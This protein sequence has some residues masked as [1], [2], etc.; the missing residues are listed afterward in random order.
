MSM[1]APIIRRSAGEICFQVDDVEP[2]DIDLACHLAADQLAITMP[3]PVVYCSL[4]PIAELIQTGHYHPLVSAVHLAFSQHRP[5]VLT[6]DVIW[7]TIAQGFAHHVRNNAESLRH[8]LVRHEGKREVSVTS[9]ELSRPEHWAAAIEGWVAALSHYS[10]PELAALLL[11][12]FS[13]TTRTA[14][15]ASQVVLMD[16]LQ[17]YFKYELISVC[18]IPSITLTGTPADWQSIRDRV[19]RLGD[20]GLGWWTDRLLVIC[21]GLIQTAVGQPP[22]LFWQHIYKPRKIYGGEVVTGWLADL[23][24]YMRH[25]LCDTAVVRNPIL[26]KRRPDVFSPDYDEHIKISRDLMDLLF[27]DDDDSPSTA[28]PSEDDGVLVVGDGL[29]PEDFPSGMSEVPFTLRFG[30]GSTSGKRSLRL[31]AGLLG[32]RRDDSGALQPEIGWAIC[33]R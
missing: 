22:R 10:D 17:H 19:E 1:L 30:Y 23:F 18:G 12:D 8:R 14:R 16:A 29:K 28:D 26:D 3:A 4:D 20:Y 21:D 2:L 31:V 13:T 6:P 25:S 15:I 33:E 27:R 9:D 24:P 11:C 7:L 5:L 32:A